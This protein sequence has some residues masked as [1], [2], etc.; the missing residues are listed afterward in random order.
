[1]NV[2]ET[3]HVWPVPFQ[4][5]GRVVCPLALADGCEACGFV[6]YVYAAYPGKQA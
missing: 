1:M 5:R 2:P 3:R 4:Y 6:G